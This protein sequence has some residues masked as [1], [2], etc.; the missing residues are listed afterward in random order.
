MQVHLERLAWKPRTKANL[1]TIPVVSIGVAHPNA[2]R[3]HDLQ[4]ML[5]GGTVSKLYGD[6]FSQGFHQQDLTKFLT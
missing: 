6:L 3:W 1:N 5:G 2:E 4:R